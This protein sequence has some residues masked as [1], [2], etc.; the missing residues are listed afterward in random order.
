M[1]HSASVASS[2]LLL[3]HLTSGCG[4]TTPTAQAP[5]N[6]EA[7]T[8][9]APPPPE[10]QAV[11]L[12]PVSAPRGT[13]LWG[14]VKNPAGLVD[15]VIAATA[16]PL[17]WRGQIERESPELVRIIS[18]DAPVELAMSLDENPRRDPHGVV[19]FGVGSEGAVLAELERQGIGVRTAA[20]GERWFAIDDAS[21]AL[22]PSLGATPARVVCSDDDD[23]LGVLL[24]YA[25]RGLPSEPLSDAEV[26]VELRA[27]PLKVAYKSEIRQLKLLASLAA[28]QIELDSA[29]FDRAATDAIMS[30]A[31]EGILLAED[32]DRVTLQLSAREQGDYELAFSTKFSKSASWTAGSVA[33]LAQKQSSLPDMFWKLPGDS[34]SASFGQTLSAERT[35]PIQENLVD[36]LGGWLEYVKIG[37]KTRVRIEALVREMMTYEGPVVSAS[38]PVRPVNAPDGTLEP[39]WQLVGFEGDAARYRKHLEELSRIL[40]SPELRKAAGSDAEWIPELTPRGALK[41]R[42]G[43]ILYEWKVSGDAAE[44]FDAHTARRGSLVEAA[45]RYSHGYVALVPDGSRTW[46]SFASERPLVSEPIDVLFQTSSPRLDGVSGITA[47]RELSSAASGFIKL[48]ALVGPFLGELTEG[49]GQTWQGI[50]RSLPY[51]GKVPLTYQ[52]RV[53]GGAAPSFEVIERVP[54]ELVADVTSLLVQLATDD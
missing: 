21:C 4:G 13:F 6:G 29:R 40:S 41:G 22:G 35:R 19:S 32:L 7:A 46:L 48:E 8:E 15:S 37:Q 43:S 17:N 24:P 3:G 11:V 39:A 50:S 36:L 27:E 1:R 52:L 26:H 47:L 45:Q 14:R 20:G 30:L 9:K 51:A 44:L 33:L 25:L 54:H 28:R 12:T 42:P 18:L 16:L 23:S 53:Q 49:R 10:A 34:S 31:E 2:L 5:T 38:G